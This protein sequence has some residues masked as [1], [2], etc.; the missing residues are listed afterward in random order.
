MVRFGDE[1][2][3]ARK[4]EES[5]EEDESGNDSDTEEVDSKV[6]ITSAQS[7]TEPGKETK[8]A[9]SNNNDQVG[10]WERFASSAIEKF[11]FLRTR[12][13]RA[14]LVHNF[15]RGLQLQLIPEGRVST[16]ILVGG[17]QNARNFA[18]FMRNE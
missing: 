17:Y 6:A 13:G 10:F 18:R 15:L 14:G 2:D 12:E 1:V 3:T 8:E 5:D 16:A 7:P 9:A 11:N 4:D